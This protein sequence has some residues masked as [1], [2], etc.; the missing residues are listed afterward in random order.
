MQSYTYIYIYALHTEVHE[1]QKPKIIC[2]VLMQQ[3]NCKRRD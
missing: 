2:P 1:I 3:V